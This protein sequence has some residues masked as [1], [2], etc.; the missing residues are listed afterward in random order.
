MWVCLCSVSSSV[1]SAL[2]VRPG[3]QT[4]REPDAAERVL[5]RFMEGIEA[6]SRCRK[7]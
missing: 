2:P 4:G 7:R 5:L 1:M 6:S 3:N